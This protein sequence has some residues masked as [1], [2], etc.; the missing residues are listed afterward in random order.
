MRTENQNKCI[1]SA[2]YTLNGYRKRKGKGFDVKPSDL[3]TLQEARAVTPKPALADWD[4]LAVFIPVEVAVRL[5][6]SLTPSARESL[7]RDEIVGGWFG[8]GPADEDCDS[9]GDFCSTPSHSD[10]V[11]S[12]REYREDL[13]HCSSDGL[14]FIY[15]TQY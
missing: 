4:D 10:D 13:E 3:L 8:G 6:A 1:A 11:V 2:C 9:D 7:I 15:S 12:V 14:L 5:Y